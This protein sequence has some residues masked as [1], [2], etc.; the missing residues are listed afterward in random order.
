VAQLTAK[1]AE[2]TA[3]LSDP[4]VADPGET[5]RKRVADR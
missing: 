4:S 1:P 2:A 3:L 5:P